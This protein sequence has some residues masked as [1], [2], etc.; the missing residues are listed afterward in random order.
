MHLWQRFGG[1]LINLSL[2]SPVYLNVLESAVEPEIEY[3]LG[4]SM[5]DP[6]HFL[7]PFFCCA[8]SFGCQDMVGTRAFDRILYIARSRQFRAPLLIKGVNFSSNIRALRY[9]RHFFDR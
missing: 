8:F 4:L 9:L 1:F 2:S 6:Q 3:F 7:D 5:I